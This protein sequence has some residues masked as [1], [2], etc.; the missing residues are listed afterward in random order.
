MVVGIAAFFYCG[1]PLTFHLLL[2]Q[3]RSFCQE[4]F[5]R[6]RVLGNFH[7]ASRDKFRH[8]AVG[9]QC[10]SMCI[11]AIVAAAVFPPTYWDADDLDAILMEGDRRHLEI[12]S[13][14]GWP[15]ERRETKL[16]IDEMQEIWDIEINGKR[17]TAKVE[18]SSA[19]YDLLKNSASLVDTV[20]KCNENTPCILR[21]YDSYVAVLSGD[22]NSFYV[23]D[24]HAR[25]RDGEVNPDGA[26]CLLHFQT[27]Q[28][29]IQYIK[30]QARTTGSM[31]QFDVFLMAVNSISGI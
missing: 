9:S 25:N 19:K 3:S 17:L 7:Q 2:F 5:I 12:L 22:N 31:E 23:F 15:L 28:G 1:T 6:T 10:S 24:S 11:S 26:S 29:L 30:L 4:A 27:R 18:I 14:K 8:S 21:L 16:G 13:G 20:L